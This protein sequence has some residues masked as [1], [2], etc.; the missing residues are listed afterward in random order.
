[1]VCSVQGFDVPEKFTLFGSTEMCNCW[2]N[3]SFCISS[4]FEFHIHQEH[5]A[6]KISGF[7]Y[8]KPVAKLQGLA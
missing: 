8:L 3:I 5:Y 4:S 1:M 2:R 7:L 6:I